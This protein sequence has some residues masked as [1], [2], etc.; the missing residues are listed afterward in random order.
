MCEG[1]RSS[2]VDIPTSSLCL[3]VAGVLKRAEMSCPTDIEE[4]ER[5]FLWRVARTDPAPGVCGL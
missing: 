1:I 3:E 5:D 2:C 4:N